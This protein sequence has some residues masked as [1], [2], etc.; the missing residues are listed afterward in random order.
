MTP[1]DIR[2]QRFTSRLLHGVSPE[3]V[4][5]FLEDVAEA[6]G[7]LQ[8]AHAGLIE[9]M[10]VLE[11]QL[12]TLSSREP[13][14]APPSPAPQEALQEAQIQAESML[15][16]ARER[17]TSASNHIEV[18]RGA[19]LRE[20]EALL[21]GAQIR[22]QSMLDDAH[23]REAT[24]QQDAE[25]VRARTQMEADEILAGATARAD[26]L[27]ASAREQEAALRAEIDRLTQSRLQ[28]VD[29][30]RGNVEAYQEWLST[31]DPRGRARS[32]REALAHSNGEPQEVATDEA[33][34][35]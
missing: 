22:A 26:A 2:S 35:S 21:H 7:A 8:T 15:N 34:V 31:M 24:L 33:R 13:Q 3:E 32:R 30:L 4:S 9:R 18:L 23:A 29:D 20:V 11:A 6:F 16:A 17:E 27:L 28:L 10:K 14:P 25:A 19:A 1:E 12:K 5:A